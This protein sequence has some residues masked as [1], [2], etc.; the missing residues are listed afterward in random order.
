MRQLEFRLAGPWAG[1]FRVANTA[2]AV[3]MAK[4]LH[5]DAVKRSTELAEGD[6]DEFHL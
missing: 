5:R 2:F 4:E 3:F 6:G 1:F